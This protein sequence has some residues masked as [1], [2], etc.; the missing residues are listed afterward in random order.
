MSEASARIPKNFAPEKYTI[1]FSPD[2]SNLKYS[3][4]TEILINTLSD[5]FPYLIL[6]AD[7]YNYKIL[8]L[9]LYKF[10]NIA[11]EW[12]EIG[13]KNPEILEQNHLF[14]YRLPEEEKQYEVQEGLYIPIEK[15][16]NKDEK[17]KLIFY[18]EGNLSSDMGNALYLATNLDEKRELFD[19]RDKLEEEWQL[20]YNNLENFPN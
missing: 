16:V 18:L 3:M 12:V 4:T 8:S 1:T 9:L 15:K 13:K 2:Y 17:L 10:D 19:D 7:K 11:D 6:N 14:Y 5:Q 20:L